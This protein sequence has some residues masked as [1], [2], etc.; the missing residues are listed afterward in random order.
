MSVKE[1]A[2]AYVGR[3]LDKVGEKE[4]TSCK[5]AVC[6]VFGFQPKRP[7]RAQERKKSE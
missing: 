4:R 3:T 7:E 2:I 1:K 5:C 6:P